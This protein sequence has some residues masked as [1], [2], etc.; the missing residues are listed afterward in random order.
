MREFRK[1]GL[2]FVSG[3][4]G[5]GLSSLAYLK[6]FPFHTVK[7]RPAFVTDVIK[8]PEDAAMHRPSSPWPTF[9]K[10]T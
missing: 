4:F 9:C 1:M 6:R 3:R 8:N 7:I 5:T 2:R 10:C